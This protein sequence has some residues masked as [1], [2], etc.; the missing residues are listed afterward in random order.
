MTLGVGSK[1]YL[2]ILNES[3]KQ[4]ANEIAVKVLQKE[5]EKAQNNIMAQPLTQARDAL[6]NALR[7]AAKGDQQLLDAMT[8][9]AIPQSIHQDAMNAALDVAANNELK[10]KH[11]SSKDALFINDVKTSVKNHITL[12]TPVPTAFLENSIVA[13]GCFASLLHM[14]SPNDYDIFILQNDPRR[15]ILH[16]D[17]LTQ[18]KHD[19]QYTWNHNDNSE[20]MGNPNITDVF[21]CEYKDGAYRRYQFI[22]TKFNSREELINDFDF[23]HCCVSMQHNKLYITKQVFDAIRNKTLVENPKCNRRPKAWRIDKFIDKGW[24]FKNETVR[25]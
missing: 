11:F 3:A 18:V 4:S 20:Y 13:G 10:N 7:G 24:K 12:L 21:T 5:Y 25:I 6:L 17:L 14:M 8:R 16:A 15:E 19:N 1:K 22:F 9:G 23:L 2:D